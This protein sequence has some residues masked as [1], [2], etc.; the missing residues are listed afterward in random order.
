MVAFGTEEELLESCSIYRDVYEVQNKAGSE[1]DFDEPGVVRY[2]PLSQRNDP[3]FADE[4]RAATR[5]R[6]GR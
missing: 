1:A 3:A 5:G 4:L 2:D 6:E